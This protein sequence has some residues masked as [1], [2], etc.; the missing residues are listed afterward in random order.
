MPVL[1]VLGYKDMHTVDNYKTMKVIFYM[2]TVTT[3]L[4]RKAD[5]CQRDSQI[6]KLKPITTISYISFF[7]FGSFSIVAGEYDL[8]TY[9]SSEREIAVAKVVMVS[10]L[11]LLCNIM[12]CISSATTTATTIQRLQFLQL[13]SN[14]H[15][16][17][18][19][20]SKTNLS[21][22]KG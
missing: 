19:P 1:H 14:N 11:K 13:L 9:E 7:R 2:F 6:P 17:T 20:N 18:R 22:L 21:E 15:D 3:K 10:I 5:L 16:N 12:Q 8:S 4:T